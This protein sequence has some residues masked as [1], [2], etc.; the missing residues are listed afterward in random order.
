MI[1]SI[2]DAYLFPIKIN[3]KLKRFAQEVILIDAAAHLSKP[4]RYLHLKKL[5]STKII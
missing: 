4:V 1:K 3:N 2:L 5:L